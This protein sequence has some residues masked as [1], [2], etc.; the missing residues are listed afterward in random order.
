LVALTRPIG[1][2]TGA[3]YTDRIAGRL[4]A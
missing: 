3:D 2:E 4:V 1:P